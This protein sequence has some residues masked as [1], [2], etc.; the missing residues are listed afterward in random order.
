[1]SLVHCVINSVAYVSIII[2]IYNLHNERHMSST[3][4]LKCGDAMVVLFHRCVYRINKNEIG[5]KLLGYW[6][7]ALVFLC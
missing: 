6:E 2:I 7:E 1:M 4:C 3:D 5:G